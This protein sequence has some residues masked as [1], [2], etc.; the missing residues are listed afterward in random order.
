MTLSKNLNWIWPR[1]GVS[2]HVHPTVAAILESYRQGQG[3]NERGGQLFVDI[4]RPDGLWL[5]DASPPHP[6]DKSGFDWLE[7][8]EDRCRQE[9]IAAN[10]QGF[11]LI[12]YWHSHPENLP[13]L[14]GQDLRSL[15]KF[16][17]QNCDD[18]PNPLAVIVGRGLSLNGIRAWIYHQ[19]QAI[20]ADSTT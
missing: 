3:E 7:M 1:F 18:L 9:I 13:N 16:S 8:N 14:S 12:G 17:R 10:A 15:K 20:P 5:V 2:I 4:T 19:E 6:M 11:R